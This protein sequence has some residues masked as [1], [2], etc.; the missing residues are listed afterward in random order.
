MLDLDSFGAV[1]QA[2]TPVAA[3]AEIGAFFGVERAG[4][5]ERLASV[6]ENL[7]EQGTL[8]LGIAL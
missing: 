5:I 6:G 8:D 2:S 3:G 4:A 7:L 1:A